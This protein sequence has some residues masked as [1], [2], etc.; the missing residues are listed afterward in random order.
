MERDTEAD[1]TFP[2]VDP[3]RVTAAGMVELIERSLQQRYEHLDSTSLHLSTNLKRVVTFLTHRE[4]VE[5]NDPLTITPAAF[6]V[7]A[8]LS[9]FGR[10]E[11]R[12]VGRLSG[13]SRQAVSTVLANL[14]RHGFIER[15]RAESVD[16]RQVI[17]DIT[18]EGEALITAGL[19]TQ[20]RTHARFFSVLDEDERAE[21]DRL[22]WK[23]VRARPDA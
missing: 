18:V 9:I 13:V 16:R 7:L 15:Q 11:A 21:F 8:M 1:R 5:V 2:A 22:L 4:D 6:R 14:E 23:L 20:N 19:E 3:A 12:D 10:M 17:V